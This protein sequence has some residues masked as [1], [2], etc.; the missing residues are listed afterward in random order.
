M[1]CAHS[2]PGQWL[3]DGDDEND[4]DV[5]ILMF[6]LSVSIHA[7]LSRRHTSTKHKIH[8]S[9]LRPLAHSLSATRRRHRA[10]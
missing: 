3:V 1:E 10:F 5:L 7:H 6:I 9:G 8:L 2:S 4:C